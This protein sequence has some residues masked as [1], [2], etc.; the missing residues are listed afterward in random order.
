[1]DDLENLLLNHIKDLTSSTKLCVLDYKQRINNKIQEKVNRS[2]NNLLANAS[3][4]D[5]LSPLKVLSRGYAFATIDNKVIKKIDDVKENENIKLS[6]SDG[7][8]NALVISKEK[9]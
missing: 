9:N 6:V 8:I 4:L 1:M 3:K 5:S 2:R 7:N